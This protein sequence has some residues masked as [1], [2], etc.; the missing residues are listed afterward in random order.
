MRYLSL[1]LLYSLIFSKE[2]Y[3]HD[4]TNLIHGEDSVA[5]ALDNG[6]AVS[7]AIQDA[8][9]EDTVILE[10]D[11]TIYYI[12]YQYWEGKDNIT[13][14]INGKVILHDDYSSWPMISDDEYYSAFDFRNSNHIQITGSGKID[15]QGFAWWSAFQNGNIVRKRP[16]ILLIINSSNININQLKL[17]NSP[18]FN[19]YGNSITNISVSHIEIYVKWDITKTFPYNTDGIDIS[20]SNIHIYNNKITN[21]DDAIAIKPMKYTCTENALIENNK[22]IYGAGI[23]IGSVPSSYHHCVKNV[24]F[25]NIHAKRPYKLIYIKTEHSEKSSTPVSMIANISYENIS[26]EYPRF[27]PIYIGPQQQK[28]PDGT[29]AGFWPITNPNVNIRNITIK[30]VVI[31]GMNAMQHVGVLRCNNTNPC[32]N[33]ILNNI[34]IKGS[35]LRY[36]CDDDSSMYGKYENVNPSPKHCVNTNYE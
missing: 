26:A 12:P 22:I 6:A 36:I 31:T 24:I 11:E 19:I 25:R 27:W 15:G 1:Q 5:N 2:I 35:N 4:Y 21:Y 18:R 14:Q 10:K 17:W 3:I 23:S 33:I 29:G 20:G 13:L 7:N 9:P 30:D 8:E 32:K 34:K 28:E 16:T